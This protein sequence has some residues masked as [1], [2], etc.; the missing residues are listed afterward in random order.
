LEVDPEAIA[1]AE[2][3]LVL[4]KV[5]VRARLRETGSRELAL[6][7]EQV[8]LNHE[9]TSKSL[10]IAV[11]GDGEGLEVGHSEVF[12]ALDAQEL[13]QIQVLLKGRQSLAGA[14]QAEKIGDVQIMDDREQKNGGKLADR[15]S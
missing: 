6:I 12:P 1:L 4:A 2:T 9:A 5:H 3:L 13:P 10:P 14:D 7:G 11:V 15:K 8:H